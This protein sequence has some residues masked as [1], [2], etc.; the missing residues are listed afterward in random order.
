MN[1]NEASQLDSM[2][3]KP[4]NNV[5]GQ[6]MTPTVAHCSDEPESEASNKILLEDEKTIDDK[7]TQQ[8]FKADSDR[9]V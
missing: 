9:Y 8:D 7:D 2:Y 4:C 5:N 1:K 6:E 3:F